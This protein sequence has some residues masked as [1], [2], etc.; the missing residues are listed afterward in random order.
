MR[1]NLAVVFYNCRRMNV[2]A[3]HIK[4]L[5]SRAADFPAAKRHP[6]FLSGRKILSGKFALPRFVVFWVRL[7]ELAV[8]DESDRVNRGLMAFRIGSR[9][10]TD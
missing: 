9:N 10:D 7:F 6:V 1:W 3:A 4:T 2:V 8:N 5:D